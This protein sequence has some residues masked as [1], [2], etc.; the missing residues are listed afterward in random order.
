VTTVIDD[1]SVV[2]R[3]AASFDVFGDSTFIVSGSVGR[4][5]AQVELAWSANF[6]VMPQGRIQYEVYRWN[7]DTQGYDDLFQ[8][9]GAQA[10]LDVVQ[11]DPY[12]K[13]EVTVGAEWQFRPDWALK[14]TAS[15]W[16]NKNYPNIYRQIDP[17][18]GLY[19]VVGNVPGAKSERKAL[20][21]AVQRRYK[22]GWLFGANYTYSQ[23][24]DNCGY[25]E[26]GGCTSNY[27]ELAVWTMED[28][29]LV[30]QYNEWG[31]SFTDATHIAK[32]RGAYQL[33]LGKGHSLNIGGLAYYVSGR[34]WTPGET[35]TIPDELN[36]LAQNITRFVNLEPA[37][38]RRITGRTQLD[39]NVEWR[40][41]IS[42]QFSGFLRTDILNATNEQSLIAIGGLPATGTPILTTDNF[43]YPRIFRA[44]VGF[45]F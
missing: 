18:D 17:V 24:L 45:Q 8:T 14:A 38:N 13:D 44:L 39:L 43:Q 42:G 31:P 33:K 40:F 11:V 28:G 23:A 10:G 25:A 26:N 6:N 16:Q 4:Y 5:V 21:V 22:N 2:P 35:W 15:Y 12:Y 30:S 9:V 1:T 27:G 7:R 34:P 37:G 41:P 19:N 29:T 20:T 3:L 32:V 36:P